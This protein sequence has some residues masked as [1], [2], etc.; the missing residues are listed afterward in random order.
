MA[1]VKKKKRAYAYGLDILRIL[2]TIAVLIYHINPDLIPGG[3]LA[4]C[5]FLVLHGYLFVVSNSTKEHFS[6]IDYYVKR[7]FRLYL[8]MAIVVFATL[9]VVSF[10]PDLMWLNKKPESVSVLLGYNNWWQISAGQSYFARVTNS[11]FT[12]MWYMAL[13]LQAEL[14]IPLI[15]RLFR[16]ATRYIKF[17][18]IWILF[19]IM[20]VLSMRVIPNLIEASAPE[21]RIYF[22]TDAR[23]FSIF[24]GMAL[25]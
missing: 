6:V 13:L 11:P 24:L 8:P 17:I 10:F 18:F 19:M 25:G 15:Y 12:H 1:E 20:T 3:F 9:Y 4:V 2:C 16:L 22:G 5:C 14:L 23:I 21:M 7:L